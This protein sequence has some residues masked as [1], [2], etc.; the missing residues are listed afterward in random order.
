MKILFINKKL[1]EDLKYK[2]EKMDEELTKK[3]AIVG[4]KDLSID[5][6]RSTVNKITSSPLGTIET[7]RTGKY[8]YL[9]LAP[10][11]VLLDGLERS[12]VLVIIRGERS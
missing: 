4:I 6:L 12:T 3:L 10:V 5:A 9:T 1:E 7:I 2:P 8:S 11:T